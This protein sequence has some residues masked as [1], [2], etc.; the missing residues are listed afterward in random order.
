M[1]LLFPRNQYIVRRFANRPPSQDGITGYVKLSVYQ[2]QIGSS[3]KALISHWF[4]GGNNS[5]IVVFFFL[6]ETTE[7]SYSLEGK[8]TF[9]PTL[10]KSTILQK[11]STKGFLSPPHHGQQ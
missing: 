8:G 7:S 3:G 4:D 10:D 1:T 9:L 6:T 11:Q 5:F 2:E